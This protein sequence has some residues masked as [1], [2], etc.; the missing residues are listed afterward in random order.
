MSG[1]HLRQ[2]VREDAMTSLQA[3][4]KEGSYHRDYGVPKL[5]LKYTV[6]DY[7]SMLNK[8][9]CPDALTVRLLSPALQVASSEIARLSIFEH[10]RNEQCFVRHTCY[11]VAIATRTFPFLNLHVPIKQTY[12]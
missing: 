4:L 12:Q 3:L 11:Y 10:A 1:E 7:T 6:L 2:A 8:Q 5:Y 9:T